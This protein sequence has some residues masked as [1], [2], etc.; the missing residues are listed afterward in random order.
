[1]QLKVTLAQIT[2]SFLMFKFTGALLAFI[3]MNVSSQ[4]LPDYRAMYDFTNSDV[5]MKGV[6]ELK[7]FEDGS[8]V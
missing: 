6:R 8:R 7:T 1:M 4:M 2:W 3:A 5:S